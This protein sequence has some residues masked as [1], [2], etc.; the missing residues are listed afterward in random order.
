MN[1]KHKPRRG[2]IIIAP[3]A[4][5]GYKTNAPAFRAEQCRRIAVNLCTARGAGRSIVRPRAAFGMT[6]GCAIPR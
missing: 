3:C 1:D 4:S 2:G 5:A 6:R